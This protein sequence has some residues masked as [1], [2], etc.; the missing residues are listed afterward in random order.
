[1]M[2]FV[3]FNSTGITANSSKVSVSR[4]Q[5]SHEPDPQEPASSLNRSNVYKKKRLKAQVV[6]YGW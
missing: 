4:V 1:M 3:A 5:L 2:V 6:S